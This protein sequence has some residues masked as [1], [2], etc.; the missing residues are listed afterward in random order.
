MS[1]VPT[2]EK[3]KL[4]LEARALA[5]QQY[6]KIADKLGTG[7]WVE[8]TDG[9]ALDAAKRSF[10]DAQTQVDRLSDVLEVSARSLGTGPAI[11]RGI[12]DDPDKVVQQ[13]S[14]N[15]AIR[16]RY[17]ICRA[18]GKKEEFD[19]LEREMDQEGRAEARSSQVTDFAPDGVMVPAFIAFGT[20]K[21]EQRDQVVGTAGS[22]GYTVATDLGE[23]IPFLSPTTPLVQLGARVV[24]GLVGNL[25]LPRRAT[26]VTGYA[27]AEQGSITESSPTWEKISLSP[28]RQGA[29]VEA[30]LQVLQQSSVDMENILRQDLQDVLTELQEY[31]AINGS[32]SSNQPTGILATA[33]IGSVVGG[34]NG[35]V[36]DWADI[37]DLETALSTANALRGMVG[38]L[39]TPGI[40]GKLKKTLLESA[41]GSE[42]IWEGPNDG[43]GTLNGYKA[44]IST[45]MP[46]TLTKGSA[47][48]ICHAIIFGNW[49]ELIMAYWGGVQIVVDPYSLAT[50][51]SVRMTA[52]TFFDVGVRHAA[53]FSAMQDALIA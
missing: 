19:G 33:G 24:T 5:K 15:R 8:D 31:Y 38:Y 16:T 36:P 17:G 2:A 41:A 22:G 34:T 52:N 12:G 29:Y 43:R 23:L 14:L 44:M 26:R 18:D 30:S 7:E 1:T 53:S 3:R 39:T 32:G 49:R 35:A 27:V 13:F 6:D 9:P 21:V 25:D 4:A 28:K 51:G 45:L 47:S 50:S 37:V 40:A 10:D 11:L 42:H 20:K 48:G 46:S